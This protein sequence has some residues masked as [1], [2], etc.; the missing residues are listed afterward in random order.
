MKTNSVLHRRKFVKTFALFSTSVCLGGKRLRSFFI[1]DVAAQSTSLIGIFRLSLDDFPELQNNF[2][3]VRLTVPGMPPSFAEIIV[4]RANAT[5]FYSVTSR[6]THEGSTVEPYGVLSQNL[7]CPRHGSR[8]SPSGS[9]VRG[10]ATSALTR[11]TSTFDGIKT[12]SISIP[13]LGYTMTAAR[14]VNPIT[15]GNRVRLEFPTITGLTY[16]LRYRASLTDDWTPVLF[17]LTADSDATETALT[18]NNRRAIV[19]VDRSSDSGFYAVV[20]Y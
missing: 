3:S 8:F 19:Y 2:G 1:T 13:N 20:R 6:C 12:V 15:S 16:E 14:T 9:V 17:A 5:T 11:Y 18:G 10:P 7:E 4:T